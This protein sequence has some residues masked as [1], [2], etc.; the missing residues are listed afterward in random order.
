MDTIA[1]MLSAVA[2]S[3]EKL[4]QDRLDL[5][6]KL[7]GITTLADSY[8]VDNRHLRAEAESLKISLKE[9]QI[10]ATNRKVMVTE[11]TAQLEVLGTLFLH[12][13]DQV[14][15]IVTQLGQREPEANGPEE[16]EDITDIKIEGTENLE[17]EI[18]EAERVGPLVGTVEEPNIPFAPGAPLPPIPENPP[19]SFFK[20]KDMLLSQMTWKERQRYL[21]TGA[22][23]PHV[24]R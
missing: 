18:M 20:R 24:R 3:A 9:W 14:T 15:K 23:P 16:K 7:S 17:V 4:E 22:V 21:K 11:L 5:Q 1:A 2:L 10:T 12:C 6:N 13:S 19:L 8:K